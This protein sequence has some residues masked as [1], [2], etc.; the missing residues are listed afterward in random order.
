MNEKRDIRVEWE[1]DVHDALCDQGGM[2]LSDARAL[3]EAQ[4]IQGHDVLVMAWV[5]DLTAIQAAK[6]IL[7]I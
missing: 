5:D 4:R 3:I 2:S 7:A 6:R 1:N